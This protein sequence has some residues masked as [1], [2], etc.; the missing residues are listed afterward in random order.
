MQNI[1]LAA[2]S[3]AFQIGEVASHLLHPLLRRMA[4]HARQ[5]HS[6][7]LQLNDEQDIVC[8]QTMPC[9]H[10]GSEEVH[11]SQHCHMCGDEVFPSG[12][13]AALG[14]GRN[15]MPAEH[16]PDRLIRDRMAEIGQRARNPVVAEVSAFLTA[17]LKAH[18]RSHA[19]SGHLQSACSRR[20]A[21]RAAFSGLTEPAELFAGQD[22]PRGD[23]RVQ[24]ARRSYR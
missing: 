17:G 23:H 2:K 19:L 15:P 20:R 9:Q 4:S 21:A 12:G 13:L 22:L 7:G 11:P 3:P 1:S 10:L 6:P 16:I 18:E 24:A 8:H 14:R 5:R